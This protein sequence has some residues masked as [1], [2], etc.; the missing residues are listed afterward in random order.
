MHYHLFILLFLTGNNREGWSKDEDE[1]AERKSLK[2]EAVERQ[3]GRVKDES[4]TRI[5]GDT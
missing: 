2:K 4:K 1:S 5:Q 3:N